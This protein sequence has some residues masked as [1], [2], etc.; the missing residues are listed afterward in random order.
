MI[1]RMEVLVLEII[2][3]QRLAHDVS[4]IDVPRKTPERLD[5]N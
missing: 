2:A 3:H 5:D 1:I 4:Q